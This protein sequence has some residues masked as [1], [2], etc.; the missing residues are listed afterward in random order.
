MKG[1]DNMQ[2]TYAKCL[3]KKVC[4]E[5][6]IEKQ[7]T[8]KTA[9]GYGIPLKTVEKWITA[10][11]KN[12]HCFDSKEDPNDFEIKKIPPKESFYDSLSNEELKH[13][14][15]KKDIEIARLKKGYQVKGG[16]LLPKEF[17]ILSKKNT[18]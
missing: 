3:K 10:Y 7:S 16:G 5:I 17:D 6:C 15:I 12:D 13:Q 14:L 2:S 11:N 4:E 8:I 1:F 9:E 18:K